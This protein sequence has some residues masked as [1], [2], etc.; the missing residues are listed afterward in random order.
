MHTLLSRLRRASSLLLTLALTALSSAFMTGCCGGSCTDA[1]VRADLG[2]TFERDGIR[3]FMESTRTSLRKVGTSVASGQLAMDVALD[4]VDRTCT[5]RGAP[6]DCA[7][8]R[9]D[10]DL[11]QY[12]RW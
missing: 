3:Y 12:I 9:A 10:P 7:T 11:G 4:V 1:I 2:N 8:L 5:S 6:V